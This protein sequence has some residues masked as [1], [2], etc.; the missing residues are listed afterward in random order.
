MILPVIFSLLIH[1]IPPNVILPVLEPCIELIVLGVSQ[2]HP[3]LHSCNQA[4]LI[5]TSQAQSLQGFLLQKGW[6]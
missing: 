1:F 5:R 4:M 6:I 2:P 3:A